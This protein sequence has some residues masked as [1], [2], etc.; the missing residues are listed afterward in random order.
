MRELARESLQLPMVGNYGVILM[1]EAQQIMPDAQQ[2]LLKELE[3][4][5]S[6][7]VWILA[8]T[9]PE[10]INR[11]VQDRCTILKVEGMTP[12]NI[13]TLVARGAEKRG[14]TGDTT[15]FVAEVIKRKL[16]S[17]RKI[18]G[19]LEIWMSGTDLHEAVGGFMNAATPVDF[20]IA[21]GVLHGNW[22]SP[23]E[24]FKKKFPAVKD[25][26][27][28]MDDQLKKKQATGD[29]LSDEEENT[30]DDE[31]LTVSGKAEKAN[32]LR[33]IVCALLKNK[34]LKGGDKTLQAAQAINVLATSVPP[35][36]FGLE[37]PCTVGGLYRVYKTLRGS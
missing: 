11:G 14:F 17:P 21:M 10:K 24:L 1:D 15:G 12:E 34:I 26:L 5:S 22:E 36:S 31:D 18:L 9:N 35:N 30:V 32:V 27:K 6:P 37:W 13:K 29:E 19:S 7:T 23:Y 33:I 8:T 2:I 16:T 20:N 3:R 25:Q 28:A 4:K